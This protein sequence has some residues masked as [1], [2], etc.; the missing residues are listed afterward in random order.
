[1]SEVVQNPALISRPAIEHGV[2]VSLFHLLLKT[3]DLKLIH[4]RKMMQL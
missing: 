1:M 4:F 3:E 2:A